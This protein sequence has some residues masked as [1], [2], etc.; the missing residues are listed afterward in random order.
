MHFRSLYIAGLL[1]LALGATT[2]GRSD[3]PDA[4]ESA[5]R[6]AETPT[7]NAAKTATGGT[8]TVVGCLTAGPNGSF[9]LT[10]DAGAVGSAAARAAS[11]TRETYTYQL[12]GGD[13]LQQHL[14]RRVEVTGTLNEDV[15]DDVELES[16]EQ[17]ATPG[18]SQGQDVTAKVETKA[19]AEIQVRELHIQKVQ[20]MADTCEPGR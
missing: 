16:K 19:E 8:T 6:P 3:R 5:T 17:S 7:A 11:G 9:V 14:G 2:C 13:N 20:Q 15:E 12:V 4:T 1:T 10:A 18:K